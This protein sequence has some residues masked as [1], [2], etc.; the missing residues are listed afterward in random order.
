MWR[1]LSVRDF[2]D[3]HAA[4]LTTTPS[5]TKISVYNAIFIRWKF[6]DFQFSGT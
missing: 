6:Y 3:L 2:Y 4:H 1:L 5:A